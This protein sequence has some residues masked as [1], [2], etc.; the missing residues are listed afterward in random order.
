[1]IAPQKNLIEVVDLKTHFPIRKGLLRRVVGS[2]KAV[3][4]VSFRIPRGKTL[5][6]VGESGCGKTTVGRTL[7][8]L[9]P[10]TDGSV[11][12]AGRD[13]F[14][15]RDEQLRLL[16]RRMQIIFQDPYGSLNPRMTVESIIGEALTVHD[17]LT[18]RKRRDK[19]VALLEKVGLSAHHADRYP[20]EFSGGQRQRIG[21]ARALALDP[22]F[23]VCD[24][25]VSA[26]DV[27]IQS[28][29]INLLKDL[30]AEMG[31]TYLFIAHD[32]AVVEHISDDVAVMYLGRIV[33]YAS[34]DALYANPLHPYTRALLSAIP[35]PEPRRTRERI[36]LKGEVPS[37][38][39]PPAG[40]PFHPRCPVATPR[41]TREV[42]QLRPIGSPG[43]LVACWKANL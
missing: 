9:I 43:H 30:Q 27:S 11:I 12:Y 28:Q 5:G 36:T 23:I 22:Q 33:E 13:I 14:M 16:R 38:S 42:Q 41:C 32:L 40:C 19:V 39:N 25:P 18:G 20:H 35:R 31:L 8:R 37:P 2:V 29:I 6:L 3:D 26:L 17:G 1:M 34:R 7:L 10:A 21:I 4:G 15:L 24:E